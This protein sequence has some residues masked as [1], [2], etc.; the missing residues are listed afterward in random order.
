MSQS[1]VLHVPPRSTHRAVVLSLGCRSSEGLQAAGPPFSTL[2]ITLPGHG[3][4]V[5]SPR[6]QDL[7]FLLPHLPQMT[8]TLPKMSLYRLF[9]WRIPTLSPL[10]PADAGGQMR[11]PGRW[12]SRGTS[13]SFSCSISGEEV[14]GDRL[15]GSGQP[16]RAHR[17]SHIPG[18]VQGAMETSPWRP[19][20]L[21]FSS[22]LVYNNMRTDQSF[23]LH[24]GKF[25]QVALSLKASH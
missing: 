3:I 8:N 13:R 20:A 15:E 24:E 17:C 14:G 22:L 1:L 21:P 2:F 4:S 5:T 18:S 16:V 11:P 23:Y 19:P 12:P 6:T 25:S 10:P 7:L 9:H